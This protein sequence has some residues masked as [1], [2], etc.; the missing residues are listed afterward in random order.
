VLEPFF[1]A[2]AS[3]QRKI[4]LEGLGLRFRVE[5][6]S[7]DESACTEK[8][9]ATRAVL[10]AKL[11]ARDVAKRFS[12]GWVLGCDTL[13]VASSGELLEKPKDAKDAERMIRLQSGSTSVV[14]SGVC[15]R[16]PQGREW[17]GCDSS[18]VTFATLSDEEI[19]RWIEKGLWEGRSGAFQIDGPGQ[20]LISRIEGDWTGIVGLPVFLL[21]EL[22]RRAEQKIT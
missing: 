9:P 12:D 22:L 4:L 3:P 20:L 10:L 8:D 21:G 14:H 6:S 11:K 1:L 7:I 13:V 18:T 5:P 19:R 15:L 2:S 16:S 17:T